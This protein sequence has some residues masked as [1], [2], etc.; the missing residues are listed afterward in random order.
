MDPDSTTERGGILQPVLQWG[1]TDD[2]GCGKFW[3]IQN[4]HVWVD[5]QG[6]DHAM[7]GPG[8]AVRVSPGESVQGIITLKKQ[9]GNSFTYLSSFKGYPAIDLPAANID[10]LPW[11]CIT[12]ECYELK[13]FSDYPDT[14][15]TAF[16][17]IRIRVRPAPGPK[18]V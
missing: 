11:A 4:W 10:E 15:F 12:L 2:P 8:N 16:Q 17:D 6:H 5:T 14:E 7:E 9:A 3:V 18:T 1:I 13:A